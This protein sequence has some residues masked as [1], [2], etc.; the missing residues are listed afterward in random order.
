MKIFFY[1][2]L[3]QKRGQTS[4]L[5]KYLLKLNKIDVTNNIKEADFVFFSLMDVM[6]IKDLVLLKKTGIKNIV[7][8]GPLSWLPLVKFLSDYQVL[9]EAY[10]FIKELSILKK[11]K[12][13]INIKNVET[14]NKK[15]EFD[16]FIDYSINPVIKSTNKIYYY[17]AS[18]GCPFKCPYCFYSHNNQYSQCNE[19]NIKNAI[20]SIPKQGKLYTTS[21]YFPYPNMDEKYLKR[22]GQIDVKVKTYLLKNF[23]GRSFRMGIEFFNEKIREKNKKP[24]T[25][26]ELNQLWNL[27]LERN[28]EITTYFLAGLEKPEGIY[29]LYKTFDDFHEKAS[30]RIFINFQYISFDEKTEF[31]GY[32]IRKRYEINTNKIQQEFSKINRRVRV[33]PIKYMASSTW[34]TLIQRVKTEDEFN[35]IYGLRNEKENNKL[36]ETVEKNYSY[37]LG[38]GD[39]RYE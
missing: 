32:D 13:I 18:K 4:F 27:S 7:V 16:Y 30:P 3:N 8:G 35:F 33:R 2:N 19:Q 29:E 9:G 39:L 34:R 12:D 37:L 31:A 17:Y 38:E 5:L 28:H 36:I 26:I 23:P 24:I 11:N 20:N 14:F 15:G 22:L 21:A 10:N 1:E 6:Y 25:N